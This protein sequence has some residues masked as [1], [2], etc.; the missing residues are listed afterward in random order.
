M[1]LNVC[2]ERGGMRPRLPATAAGSCRQ[3][4]G[5][6]QL[7]RLP[8]G[9]GCLQAAAGLQA[10][11]ARRSTP[12]G[13]RRLQAAA[14]DPEQGTLIAEAGLSMAA[15]AFV[16]TFGVAPLFRWVLFLRGCW[17]AGPPQHACTAKPA[18]AP[19]RVLQG[20][21]QGGGAVAAGLR[22]PQRQRRRR[23]HQPGGRIRE[24]RRRAAR[25]AAALQ[26]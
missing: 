17:H 14:L 7:L 20:P 9:S 2:G 21:V 10:A 11:Q 15:L 1:A 5:C 25:R 26:V 24:A 3:L 23:Q 12:A 16:G 8:A 6:R 13:R 18:A 22:V 4:Q 19:P